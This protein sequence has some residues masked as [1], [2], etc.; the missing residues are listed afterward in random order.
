M[1]HLKNQATKEIY[2]IR[3]GKEQQQHQLQEAKGSKLMFF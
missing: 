3:W 2:Y 1:K